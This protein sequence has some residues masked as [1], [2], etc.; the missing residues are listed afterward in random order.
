[1]IYGCNVCVC[2]LVRCTA[3]WIGENKSLTAA[4]DMEYKSSCCEVEVMM[5]F[6][7]EK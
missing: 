5:N 2:E 6:S 4:E 1:M 7:L 3:C